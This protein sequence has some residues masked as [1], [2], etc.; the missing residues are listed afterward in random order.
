V[1]HPRQREDGE[2]DEPEALLV[3][4]E[5]RGDVAHEEHGPARLG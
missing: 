5:Q 4:A 2:D 1:A 3:V